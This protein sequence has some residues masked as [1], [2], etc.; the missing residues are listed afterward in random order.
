MAVISNDDSPGVI[1]HVG[2]ALGDAGV[3][4]ANMAVGRHMDEP[5]ALMGINLDQ[6]PAA[7]VE[8]T[9]RTLPGILDARFL[10]LGG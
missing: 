7:P 5:Y 3:N 2:T 9:L 8:A 4:I 10:D 1:G 6:K